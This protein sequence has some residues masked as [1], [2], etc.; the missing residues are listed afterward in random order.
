MDTYTVYRLADDNATYGADAGKFIV[1]SDGHNNEHSGP[2]SLRDAEAY[3]A[4]MNALRDCTELLLMDYPEDCRTVMAARAA[5][6]KALGEEGR[7]A[8]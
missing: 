7:V 5:M 2:M 3:A 4:M 8:A 1:T 6:A